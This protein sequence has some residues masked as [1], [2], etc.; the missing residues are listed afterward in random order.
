LIKSEKSE[1]VYETILSHD[2]YGEWWTVSG[3]WGS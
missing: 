3:E 2:W 1:D